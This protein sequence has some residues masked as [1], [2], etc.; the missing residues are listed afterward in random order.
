MPSMEHYRQAWNSVK[1]VFSWLFYL[2]GAVQA[3]IISQVASGQL[4]HLKLLN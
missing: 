1:L 3:K 4:V 2:A